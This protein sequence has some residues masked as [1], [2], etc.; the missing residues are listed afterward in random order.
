M[1]FTQSILKNSINNPKKILTIFLVDKEK[2][3]FIDFLQPLGHKFIYYDDL[4]F[5]NNIPN[6]LICNN[7]I[8]YYHLCKQ[9][10]ISY[11]IPSIIIDHNIKSDLYDEDKIKFIDNL[12]CSFKI[13]TN[14]PIY[15]S[16]H[17]IHDKILPY[18][19]DNSQQLN[20]W[21]ELL[22]SVSH[23]EFTI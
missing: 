1:N 22:V 2:P 18:S 20:S 7:K 4:Y 5:G 12:P 17:S 23:K 6:L 15:R 16:W 8:E 19:K 11:H 21:S 13:A 3:D 9:L 10:S 14:I